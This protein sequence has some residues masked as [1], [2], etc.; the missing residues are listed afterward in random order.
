M[1]FKLAWRNIWRNK[2]RTFITLAMIQFAVVLATFMS[3]FRYGI[4]DAQVENVVGGYQGYGAINDTSFVNEPNIENIVPFNDSIKHYLNEKPDIKAYSPRI[5]GVGMMT[6][7]EK[8]KI[9]KIT[10]IEP[11]LEDSLTHLSSFVVRGRLMNQSGEVVLGSR[12]SK[13]LKADLDSVV[14]VTGMGYHGNTANMLLKVVGIINLSNLEED[15]RLAFITL[16]EAREGFAL[17]E[18]VN[19]IVLGFNNNS[20]AISI[21]RELK[22]DFELP[23]QVYSWSELNESLYMLVQVNDAAN[24]IISSIL[25]FVIS[26]GLF[27]TILMMLSERKREFGMLIAIGMKKSKLAYVVYFENLL[28]GIT[29]TG[30]GFLIAIPLVYYFHE[31]P[32]DLTGQMADDIEKYGFEPTI[33]T[34]MSLLMFLGQALAVLSITLIFSLYSIFRIRSMNAIKAMHE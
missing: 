4:L 1:L 31:T 12:L 28:M 30:I 8:F 32:I 33:S 20:D 5:L 27:G 24:V 11:R 17:Y 29:G 26:F 9:T 2:R 6:C 19:Q 3:A 13:R 7:G 15:K 21:V 10:G 22:D 18:G 23:T 34:S 14:F 25:Y 16:D